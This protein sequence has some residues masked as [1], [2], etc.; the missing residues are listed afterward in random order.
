MVSR[1]LVVYIWD[2]HHLAHSAGLHTHSH[3]HD[4]YTDIT[5]TYAR[6]RR[7]SAQAQVE[8]AGLSLRRSS[9]AQVRSFDGSIILRLRV[10]VRLL[11]HLSFGI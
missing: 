8:L 3:S 9:A 6:T 11:C 10:R 5:R 1:L 7:T 2:S 4:P